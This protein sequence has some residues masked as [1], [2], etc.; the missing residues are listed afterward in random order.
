MKTKPTANLNK[1]GAQLDAVN[2]LYDQL[3]AWL[4]ERQDVQRARRIANR[5]A[6]LLK[7]F[8]PRPENI[9]IE[10]CRSLVFEA[11]G[12]LGRAIKHRENEIR[13]IRRLHKISKGTESEAYVFGQYDYADLSER[14]DIL[15]MLY[16]RIGNLSKAIGTLQE[17]KQLCEKH[18]VIFDGEAL[19]LEYQDEIR[20]VSLSVN[21]TGDTDGHIHIAIDT[22]NLRS[23]EHTATVWTPIG[24][25]RFPHRHFEI[26]PG[27]AFLLERGRPQR[28]PASKV[29]VS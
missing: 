8:N 24:P 14:M 21:L 23:E 12:D 13:L 4:Y 15:A 11:K 28:R 22:G 25:A 1:N 5:L 20:T 7:R 19:L 27:G 29:L 6:A 17:S 3:V 18:E 2:R 26:I 9:F 16:R 10:E